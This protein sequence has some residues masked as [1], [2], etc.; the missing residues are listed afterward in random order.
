MSKIYDCFMFFNELDL[1]EIRFNE[2]CDYVDK[3]VIVE[4][5]QNHAGGA[6]E[7]IFL[8]NKEKFKFFEDKIIHVIVND[9]MGNNPAERES[10][11]RNCINR[12]LYECSD[13]DIIMISDVDEIPRGC[14]IKE[15]DVNQGIMAFQQILSYYFFNLCFGKWNGTKIGTF[16]DLKNRGSIQNMRH[17]DCPYILN[18]GWHFSYMGGIDAIINKIQSF[19]H[20][21]LNKPNFVDERWIDLVLSLG[22]DIFQR[23]EM[24]WKF[25][26]GLDV[27]EYV[28]KNRYDKYKDFFRY[29]SFNE[30]WISNFQLQQLWQTYSSRCSNLNG[31]IVEI[32][33][34]E[35]RSTI[36]LAKAAYPEIVHAVDTWKGNIGEGENHTTIEILKDRDV[37][38]QFMKNIKECKINNIIV[39]KL[40]SKEFLESLEES[41]KF[42]HIDG[43]HDY[44]S[45]R[46]EISFLLPIIVPGGVICGDDLTS[47]PGVRQA[48]DELLVNYEKC[49]NMFIWQKPLI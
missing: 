23:D 35:G 33:C 4:S 21:E 8:K 9:N 24:R 14:K 40:S 45:V 47:A 49:G 2:L 39:Y 22:N 16:K 42:V 13:D 7:L 25:T 36:T 28:N 15:Y 26:D 32:G 17:V 12:G 11:N 10:F 20:Q 3:F 46:S 34:W 6:K 38:A 30:Y 1:L 27:P 18:G 31:I 44:E 37:F 29:V 43:S 5:L 41:I 19:L 48:V